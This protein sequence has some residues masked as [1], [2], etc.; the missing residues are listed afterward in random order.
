MMLRIPETMETAI[1]TSRRTPSLGKTKMAELFDEIR[2]GL[3]KQNKLTRDKQIEMQKKNPFADCFPLLPLPS[4]NK[5]KT[6]RRSGRSVS[7]P[8]SPLFGCAPRPSVPAVLSSLP[9]VEPTPR[10]LKFGPPTLKYGMSCSKLAYVVNDDDTSSLLTSISISTKAGEKRKSSESYED[11]EKMLSS[12]MKPS[13]IGYGATF[14]PG[15]LGFKKYT[16]K[17]VEDLVE[18]ASK[19]IPNPPK[20]RRM[21]E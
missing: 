14:Y 19:F 10:P 6:K 20:K 7:P 3:K 1:V 9:N 21:V 17:D 2:E 5:K 4:L 16:Q 18:F 13:Y 12:G 15:P 11:K 8:S